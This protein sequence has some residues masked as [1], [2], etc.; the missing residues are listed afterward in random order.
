[1]S[2]ARN[3]LAVQ[4]VL[5][6]QDWSR[7][8]L[9]ALA[10]LLFSLEPYA[11]YIPKGILEKIDRALVEV[12]GGS[13]TREAS[14]LGATIISSAAHKALKASRKSSI[15]TSDLDIMLLLME[16]FLT[17]LDLIEPIIENIFGK[18]SMSEVGKKI[19]DLSRIYR[20]RPD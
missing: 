20:R 8:F 6:Q 18:Q 4:R 12:L 13:S 1:M 5:A 7:H 19:W 9:E 3:K 2:T 14:P 17:A 15:Q 16:P 11:E 10:G